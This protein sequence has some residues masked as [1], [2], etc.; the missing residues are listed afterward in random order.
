MAEGDEGFKQFSQNEYADEPYLV[1]PMLDI[2]GKHIGY[3]MRFTAKEGP[4]E[5][6]CNVGI[7]SGVIIAP[8][9][10]GTWIFTT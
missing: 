2:T 9:L 1:E 7:W 5:L 3:V 6:F 4:G 10:F 8:L